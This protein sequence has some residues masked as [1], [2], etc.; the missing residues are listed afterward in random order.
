MIVDAHTHILPDEFRSERQRMLRVDGTFRSL[1]TAPARTTVSAEQLVG[2]MDESGV[3]ASVAAGYGWTDPGVARLANDYALDAARRFPGRVV[4][5]CSVNPLWGE[6]AVRELTRCADEG[7]KGLGELHPDPQ[8]FADADLATLAPVLDAARSMGLVTLLH[9]SEPVG[10]AY[11][12]KGTVTPDMLLA[13]VRAYP[14]NTFVFAHF[15][16]GLPFYSLMPEVELALSNVYF[17]SAA[18]PFLYLPRVFDTAI[19][20]AGAD[21]I[22]FGSDYPL[23]GQGR[24]LAGFRESGVSGEAQEAVLGGNA[25]RLFGL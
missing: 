25:A 6:E 8:G 19:S 14:R 7:A 18:F 12:G 23:I 22:L 17:D 13:L 10:H 11:P 15:G 2:E 9:A 16:G 4:P 5:F 24:S 3:Q 21:R 20:A 1:F